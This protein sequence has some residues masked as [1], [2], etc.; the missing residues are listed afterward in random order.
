MALV[1]GATTASGQMA[2]IAAVAVDF[3]S[4]QPRTYSYSVPAGLTVGTG[5]LVWVPFGPRTLQGVVMAMETDPVAFP[6]RPIHS[7]VGE[8]PLLSPPQLDLARWI[9]Q[10]YL[11]GLFAAAAL[12]LPP[13]MG[14]RAVT[15]LETVAGATPPAALPKE[16]REVLAAISRGPVRLR[17]LRERFGQRRAEQAIE[18]L[19]RQDLVLRRVSLPAP[20]ARP[21]TE[22]WLEALP[23]PSY[24]AALRRAPRRMA[25]YEHLLR[26]GPQRTAALTK[27]GFSGVQARSLKSLGLLRRSETP[28]LRDPLAHRPIPP[29]SPAPELT[30]AQGRVWSAIREA[31]VYGPTDGGLRGVFLL[32]GVTGSGK[33]E[34][35]LRAAH[36]AAGRGKRTLM[37]VPE[38][39]LTSQTIDRF[40]AR[41]PGRV[42]ILHSRLTLGQR[43]DEWHRIRNGV[44]DVVVGSRGAVFAPLADLGVIVV[45]EEHEWTFKQTETPPRFHAR[46][47]AL[48][49][50]ATWGAVVLLGSATPSV[51][52]YELARRGTYRLLVLP[53]RAP[54]AGVPGQLATVELVD[55]RDELRS[56]HDDIFSRVL[57]HRLHDT[58]ATGG[59]AILFLNRRGA[60]V[61]VQC[62][63]CGHAM[64]CRR[65]DSMLAYH[66]NGQ[67]LLCHLCGGRRPPPAL[68]PQCQGPRIRYVGVGTEGLEAEVRRRFPTARTMR[69]DRDVATQR[70]AH[71]QLLDRFG[72]READI[73]IGT[74]MVAKGLDFPGVSLVGVVNADMALHLPDFR[75][76]ERTF[77][78]LTQVAGRAGRGSTPGHVVIQ[79]Y[80]PEHYAVAAA[81][82]QDYTAF[83][84]REI[85]FRREHGYPP[86]SQVVRL[87]FHHPSA[88]VCATQAH[89]MAETLR[90]RVAGRGEPTVHVLGPTPAYVGRIRGRYR[91]QV[92][93]RGHDPVAILKGLDLPEPWIV[94]VDPAHLL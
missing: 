16:M 77:Q 90:Q 13:G 73:L 6:V 53:D 54:A 27:A 26:A 78:L 36:E 9:S 76:A 29:A 49:L 57:L 58:L 31:L 85:A 35:Y 91:W 67:Y 21:T 83:F 34:L 40:A 80:N 41:L 4:L 28:L 66:E 32:H 63:R 11:S 86:Y 60:A 7:V 15:W 25:L 59:Q 2:P 79:T 24:E 69:L 44:F 50:A 5:H 68:C 62:R 89:R 42:A 74:Q 19:A 17:D 12:M 37:L 20:R 39:A 65:C 10:R 81:S 94:D 87:L 14:A 38:I 23:S 72:A 61:F 52:S 43:Y 88:S 45:D 48:R 1:T 75:N 33:T 47:V 51:E 93:L 30:P 92:L 46:E 56:G 84:Q 64:R 18:G 70:L 22:S 3:P 55:L 82:R 71:E 8:Q